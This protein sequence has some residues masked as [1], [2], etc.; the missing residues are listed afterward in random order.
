MRQS[1]T[2]ILRFGMTT[3]AILAVLAVVAS[4]QDTAVVVSE[5]CE[6]ETRRLR[7]NTALQDLAPVL[8]CNINF[9]ISNNCTV[10]YESVSTNYS[11]VCKEVNGQFY[12]TDIVLDCNVS[13]MGND[14]NGISY[15]RNVPSCIGVSCTSSEVEI[16][17]ET[18]LFRKLEDDYAALG[19]QC[20][21]TNGEISNGTMIQPTI[22]QYTTLFLAATVIFGLSLLV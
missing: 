2:I 13:L 17:F 14:Y 22:P 19:A 6:T 7:N 12:T 5:Q 21:A 18:N 16:E 10:D 3:I 4:A 1:N 8:Q 9:D 11:N 15:Y 20:V